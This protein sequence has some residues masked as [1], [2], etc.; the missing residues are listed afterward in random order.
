MSTNTIIW[1][2]FV[3]CL[4]VSF[5]LSGMEAGVFAL[6]RLRI[7]QQMRAGKASAKVLHDYLENPEDFLWTILV[8]NT[9]ANFLILGWLVVRLHSALGDFR[10]WF[11]VVFSVAVFLFYAFFD[12]LPKML[13]RMYPNRLCVLLARPFRFLHLALRPLV[14]LVETFSGMLL[15]WRGGKV[16]TG[17]LFG[18][19]EELRLVM[20]DSAQA[21]TSEERAMINR[22]LDLQTLTVRQAM[23]PLDQA[24]AITAQTPVSMA[25]ALCRERRLTRLPVWESRDGGQRIIGLLALNTLLYQPALDMAKPVGDYVK[26]ALFLDEDLRLEVALRRLQR[27]GQR[28]AIVLSRERRELGILSLQ[29]V[30]KVIFGEVSL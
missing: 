5:V 24:V 14:A 29:D 28:L 26:P 8:G 9:V 23:K 16:F 1:A 15:R 2:A 13:F 19:R 4:A 27:S 30:L 11:V 12:L 21:F 22:V 6:S 18:N 10:I 25:L 20:Q 7:R 3:A 17:H